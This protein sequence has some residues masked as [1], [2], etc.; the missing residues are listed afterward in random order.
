MTCN[1]KCSDSV[2]YSVAGKSPLPILK[3]LFSPY[4]SFAFSLSSKQHHKF[5]IL[6]GCHQYHPY[7]EGQIH[8][9][10]LFSTASFI[11]PMEQRR[12]QKNF[13]VL[14]CRLLQKGGIMHFSIQR[15]G[16]QIN[17]TNMK[18]LDTQPGRDDIRCSRKSFKLVLKQ[19]MLALMS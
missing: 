3:L 17:V 15:G 18:K 5:S 10:Q 1:H 16:C 9:V 19:A 2:C 7:P 12:M 14:T 6:T 13:N 11:F 4:P 8:D